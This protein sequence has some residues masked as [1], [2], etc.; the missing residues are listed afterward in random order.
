MPRFQFDASLSIQRHRALDSTPC[1]PVVGSAPCSRC[2]PVLSS[3]LDSTPSRFYPLSILPR[4]LNSAVAKWSRIL[5]FSF[6]VGPT[7]SA[8]MV[9][10]PRRCVPSCTVHLG[11]VLLP[12]VTEHRYLGVNLTST[13]SWVAHT[14][15]LVTR[16]NRLLAQCVAWCRTEGLSLRFASTLHFPR[17]AQHLLGDRIF[18]HFSSFP[19]V[20]GL[21][22]ASVGCIPPGM[23][24]WFS[25]WCCSLGTWLT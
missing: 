1:H 5:R 14:R 4:T 3:A 19:P 18:L 7:K 13:L 22:S 17:L 10:G 15:H 11:G 24:F 23:A 8:M 25:C 12:I 2:C 6:G 21:C 20:G 16:A 9:F